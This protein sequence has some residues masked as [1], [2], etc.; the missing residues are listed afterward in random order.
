MTH[1]VAEWMATATATDLWTLNEARKSLAFWSR[2]M[3]ILCHKFSDPSDEYVSLSAYDY[4]LW[5]NERSEEP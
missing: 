5:S 4:L 3:W 2:G 1:P